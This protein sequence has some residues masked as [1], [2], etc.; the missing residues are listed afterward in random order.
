MKSMLLILLLV[1]FQSFAIED[2]NLVAAG[3]WSEPVGT[4]FG[5]TIRGR[6]LVCDTPDHASSI[7][8]VDNAVYLELQEFASSVRSVDVYCQLN[9]L[10]FPNDAPG[11]CCELR[12]RADKVV[13]ESGGAFSGGEPG[14]CWVTLNSYCSARL[15]M[16]AFGAACRLEDGGLHI[17]LASRGCW[18]VHPNLTN[19]Y[20][21]SGTFTAVAPTNELGFVTGT[22]HNIWYGTL[23]LPKMKLPV[24]KP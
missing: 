18:D 3:E 4:M 23:K 8:R 13:P 2:T 12:D 24:K 11:L 22:N 10:E 15:R 19:D 20:Y 1:T 14:N 16:S 9:R 7:Q 21:F 5:N 17:V 6:L